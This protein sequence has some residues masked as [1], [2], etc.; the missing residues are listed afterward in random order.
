MSRHK[1]LIKLTSCC[2]K[3]RSKRHL[4][5]VDAF[6]YVGFTMLL[7]KYQLAWQLRANSYVPWPLLL[8]WPLAFD[9]TPLKF[10]IRNRSRL[11]VW[12]VTAGTV[13][14]TCLI[15]NLPCEQRFLSGVVHDKLF[16]ELFSCLVDSLTVLM[17]STVV[18]I[19]LTITDHDNMCVGNIF[20][21]VWPKWRYVL[22]RPG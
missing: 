20:S 22:S 14:C 21:L 6:F 9:S 2:Y 5:S 13:S 19:I 10:D 4:D 17:R 7:N 1:T 8:I 16:V 11:V 15:K 12:G 18:N 3:I